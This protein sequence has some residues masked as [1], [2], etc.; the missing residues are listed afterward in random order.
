MLIKY[1]YL[2]LMQSNPTVMH[3]VKKLVKSLLTL[4]MVI[5]DF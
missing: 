3:T 1:T 5:L 2:K 4:I